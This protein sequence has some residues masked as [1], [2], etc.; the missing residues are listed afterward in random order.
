MLIPQDLQS[1]VLLLPRSFFHAPQFEQV[2][3]V[4]GSVLM[5]TCLPAYLVDADT[6]LS[7][8]L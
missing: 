4:P 1:Y 6:S 5:S 7:L 3:E 8:N 2:P